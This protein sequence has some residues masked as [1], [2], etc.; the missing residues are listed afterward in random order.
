MS[1]MSEVMWAHVDYRQDQLRREAATARLAAE[2]RRAR[3]EANR[4]A[5]DERFARAAADR[6][7][8][9]ERQARKPTRWHLWRRARRRTSVLARQD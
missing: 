2:L 8:T 6:P 7:A 9:A 4:R 1:W 5:A 3:R